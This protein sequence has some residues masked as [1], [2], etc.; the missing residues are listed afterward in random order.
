MEKIIP[1]IEVKYWIVEHHKHTINL[2]LWP[3]YICTEASYKGFTKILS[4]VAS[5]FILGDFFSFSFI[6]FHNCLT[7][8]HEYMFFFIVSGKNKAI[9]LLIGKNIALF[10][11]VLLG[12][13]IMDHYIHQNYMTHSPLLQST[14]P[15]QGNNSL[16]VHP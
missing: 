15:S 14:A 16:L 4:M 6:L 8:L 7:F 2:K 3:Q 1:F 13:T 11:C 9:F 10:F 5:G 12:R